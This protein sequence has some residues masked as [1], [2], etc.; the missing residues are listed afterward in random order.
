[1]TLRELTRRKEN[2]CEEQDIVHETYLDFEEIYW[3]YRI[4]GVLGAK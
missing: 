4:I 2:V 1:M 3:M